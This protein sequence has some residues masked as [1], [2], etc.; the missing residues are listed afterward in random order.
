LDNEGRAK[1]FKEEID[2]V[3][4]AENAKRAAAAKRFDPNLVLADAKRVHALTDEIL[5]VVRYGVLSKREIDKLNAEEPDADKR[6]YRMIFTMLQKG[7]PDLKLEDVEE[8]PYEV[9][10]RLSEILSQRFTSFLQPIPKPFPN[11]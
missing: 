7:Y 4:A 2:K 9:V 3:E 6:A 11:G 8:W 1:K 10:A 5:G